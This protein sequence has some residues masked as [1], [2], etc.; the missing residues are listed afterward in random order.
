VDITSNSFY[1]CTATFR[2]HCRITN[3]EVFQ[4]ANEERLLLKILKNRRHSWAGHII[5]HNEFAVNILEG[6]ISG[7]NALGRP[8]LQ[9]L[10]QVA[11][12]TAADSCTVM[13]RMA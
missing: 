3:D 8:G 4:R 1:K 10:Q 9:Y 12:N 13:E 11:R 6:A 5:R 2:T 7:K